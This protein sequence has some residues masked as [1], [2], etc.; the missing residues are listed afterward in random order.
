LEAAHPNR[1][2]SALQLTGSL[3]AT[4]TALTSTP[5]TSGRKWARGPG[6]NPDSSTPGAARGPGTDA[7][8]GGPTIPC[9][10][11]PRVLRTQAL[12][13][14]EY[15]RRASA[16][17]KTVRQWA[18]SGRSKAPLREKP[19]LRSIRSLSW[20]PKGGGGKG[21]RYVGRAGPP[22]GPLVVGIKF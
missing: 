1:R 15:P 18:L 7:P 5:H 6:A 21:L 14:P 10:K 2:S 16:I 11:T 9:A 12:L 20:E 13:E 19:L 22:K 17:T 4:V 8:R 3:T